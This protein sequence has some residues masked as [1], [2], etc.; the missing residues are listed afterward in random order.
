MGVKLAEFTGLIMKTI[1][2]T[3][4]GIIMKLTRRAR[5]RILVIVATRAAEKADAR[6]LNYDSLFD[7]L[8]TAVHENV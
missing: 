8:I 1:S 7:G 4:E 6:A 2:R 3:P 5:N